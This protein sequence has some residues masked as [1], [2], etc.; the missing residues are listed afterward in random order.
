[1][2][3]QPRLSDDESVDII[4]LSGIGL[5]IDLLKFPQFFNGP[6]HIR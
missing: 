3:I 1:M 5:L 6:M 2:G 4:L